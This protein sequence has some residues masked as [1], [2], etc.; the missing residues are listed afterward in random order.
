MELDC[1]QIQEIGLHY[2]YDLLVQ[3]VKLQSYRDPTYFIGNTQN[4]RINIYNA[5]I[6]LFLKY[7]YVVQE[8]YTN[9]CDI[10]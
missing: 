6:T 4:Q 7:F 3:A 9:G 5:D 2:R 10:D 1:R 8:Y